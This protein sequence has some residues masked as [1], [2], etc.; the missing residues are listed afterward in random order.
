M[1]EVEQLR[2]DLND[3]KVLLLTSDQYIRYERLPQLVGEVIHEAGSEEIQL[4]RDRWTYTDPQLGTAG[5]GYNTISPPAGA[6]SVT[7]LNVTETGKLMA[8]GMLCSSSDSSGWTGT[9][10]VDADLRIT[11]DGGTAVNMPL[12]IS[13]LPARTVRPK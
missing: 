2:A 9:E 13:L 8:I 5:N 11:I 3:L 10:T 6:A 1:T 7:V 4:V 12:V